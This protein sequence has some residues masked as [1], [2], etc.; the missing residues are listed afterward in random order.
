MLKRAI[1]ILRTFDVAGARE[2][3]TREV[4]VTDPSGN[5]IVF[6]EKVS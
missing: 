2:W 1:P 4:N 6:S 5:S 3:G